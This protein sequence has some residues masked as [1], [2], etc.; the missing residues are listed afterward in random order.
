M[1]YGRS[2]LVGGCETRTRR[3][4]V[5]E[6]YD[7]R[8]DQLQIER[9]RAGKHL[10]ELSRRESPEPPKQTAEHGPVVVEHGIVTVLQER[11]ADHSYLFARR[12]AAGDAA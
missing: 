5:N 4:E 10:L 12:P 8:L 1:L 11:R 9:Q 2:L 3:P 7:A 6:G